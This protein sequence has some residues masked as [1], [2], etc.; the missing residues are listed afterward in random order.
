MM[1]SQQA[2]PPGGIQV[3]KSLN[4]FFSSGMTIAG[5]ASRWDLV[6][7]S[8]DSILLVVYDVTADDD[9]TAGSTS[10]RDPGS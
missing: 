9:V 4:R 10:R 1:T 2:P 8:S 6:G 3:V 5:S 7:K